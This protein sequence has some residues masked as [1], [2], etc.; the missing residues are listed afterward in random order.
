MKGVNLIDCF[1]NNLSHGMD[2]TNRPKVGDGLDPILLLEQHNVSGV[3]LIDILEVDVGTI[4]HQQVIRRQ[5]L[6]SIMHFLFYEVV[7]G[8]RED[9]ML[10]LHVVT[11]KFPVT[12]QPFLHG[13]SVVGMVFS[14]SSWLVTKPDPGF[15]LRMK[16]F[17]DVH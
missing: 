7:G 12:P 4:R 10:E 13:R 1:C 8:A 6:D 3:E 15:I 11:I 2:K 17:S 14:M 9:I 16:F 5:R